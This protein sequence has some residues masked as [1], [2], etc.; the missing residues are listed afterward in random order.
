MP[1]PFKDNISSLSNNYQ[2]AAKRLSS[3]RRRMLM[4]P[5]HERELTEAITELS[6]NQFMIPANT[7]SNNHVNYL[8]YF[9]TTQSKP[10]VVYDGSAAFESNSINNCIYS[11]P[12]L[13]NPLSSVL[14]RFRMRQYALMADIRKCFS[15]VLLPEDQ[16]DLFRI[17][18]FQNDDIEN[19]ERKAHTF[20]RHLWGIISSPYTACT[21]HSYTQNSRRK[22]YQ[23]NIS[24]Y[25]NHTELLEHGWSTIQ[26]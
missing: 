9:L 1:V 20:T 13:L 21:L 6:E 10:K 3:L 14:A 7:G 26:H 18:W 8:P 16:Q 25:K 24:F 2:L 11:G 12:D 5:E 15:Q 17:L 23:R 22:P 4:K 19:G